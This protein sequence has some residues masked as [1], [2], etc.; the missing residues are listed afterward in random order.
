MK[1][2]IRYLYVF[3]FL[4]VFN[5]FLVSTSVAD[6]QDLFTQG[7]SYTPNILIILD[8]SQSMDEDF[9]GNAVARGQQIAGFSRLKGQYSRSLINIKVPKIIKKLP[10]NYR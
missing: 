10:H 8:N 6:D 1:K 7:S 3:I 9:N 5:L 4:V 2:E